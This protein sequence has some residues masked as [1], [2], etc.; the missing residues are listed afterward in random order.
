MGLVALEL[1]A[2]ILGCLKHGVTTSFTTPATAADLSASLILLIL[3]LLEH[4]RSTRPSFLISAY[5]SIITLVRSAVARTY[6]L[7]N[8]RGLDARTALAS[9]VV[10]FILNVIEGVSKKRWLLG[11]YQA[12]SLE[13]NAGF[14][15]RSFLFWLRR[16][17]SAG[18]RRHL[19]APDIRITHPSLKATPLATRFARLKDITQTQGKA[20]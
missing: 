4:V 3:S 11:T 5:L 20:P 12:T 13:E 17:F 6:W 15:D 10:L 9:V 16:L 7:M 8:H 19:N 2:L 14:Y 18:Y 1:T